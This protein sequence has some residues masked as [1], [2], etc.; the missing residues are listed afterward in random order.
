VGG[1]HNAHLMR[2]ALAVTWDARAGR[3]ETFREADVHALLARLAEA[4]LV[5][6]FNV[7]G[8]DYRVLRGYTDR[9]LER[10]PT[11]D[12]LEAVRERIGFR[13]PLGHL[14]E[15]N[16]GVAKGGDGLQSLQW[17]REGRIAEIEEYCRQDVALLRDLFE[18][19]RAQGHLLFRTR[20]GE[21]VRIPTPWQLADL[22]ERA[23]VR[24]ATPLSAGRG[25]G[26]AGAARA[27]RSTAPR[28]RGGAPAAAPR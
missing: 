2:V 16:L 9:E 1:W 23:R 19:G 28:A 17:W 10:L 22:L 5:V 18:R 25:R 3:F 24:A 21:R 11:F 12:V 20:D 4:E 15:E 26:A 8:F 7:L 27:A 6:G 13:L 14:A